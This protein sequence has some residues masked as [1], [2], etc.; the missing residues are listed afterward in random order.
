MKQDNNEKRKIEKK[1]A[2]ALKGV[3]FSDKMDK[4]IVVAVDRLKMHPKYKKRY[5]V[6]KKYKAHDEKNEL[7]IGDKVTIIECRPMS[8][9]KRWKTIKS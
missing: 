5:K 6:T 1:K 8:K 3:V 2:R 4:T 9:D 7:H